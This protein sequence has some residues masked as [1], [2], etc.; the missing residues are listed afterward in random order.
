MS[1]ERCGGRGRLGSLGWLCAYCKGKAGVVT[2]RKG[3]SPL[4]FRGG[5]SKTICLLERL[6]RIFT[7]SQAKGGEK[8]KPLPGSPDTPPKHSVFP[9]QHSRSPGFRAAAGEEK[10][11]WTARFRMPINQLCTWGSSV[12]PETG[13]AGPLLSPLPGRWQGKAV[14][15]LVGAGPTE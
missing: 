14:H 15:L 8:G 11:R 5:P 3:L 4:S 10:P 13:A 9:G 2:L 7:R 6:K 1:R 12:L